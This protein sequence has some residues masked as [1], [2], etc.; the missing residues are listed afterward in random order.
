LSLIYKGYDREGLDRQY[1]LRSLWPDVPAVIDRREN[2]SA[3]VR[4]RINGRLD[5]AYGESAGERLD[6]F[7]PSNSRNGG[8]ALIYIHGGYWQLSDKNDT[9]YIAPAFL[10]AGINFITLNYTLAPA[11]T[12][13]DMVRQCRQAVAWIWHHAAEIG[14]NR[15]RLHLAGHSAGGH[16]TAMMLATDWTK[17]DRGLP[18]DPIAG[19]CALSGLYDLEPIRL[20]FV[21]DVLGLEAD[22]VIRNSPLYLDPLLNIPVILS[23]G[24]NE[25]DE[26]KR[27][28]KELFSAWSAKGLAVEQILAPDCHHYTIVEH[29]GD[30][31]GELHRA[32]I[33]MMR[34]D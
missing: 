2:E 22:A 15:D 32:M 27:H 20:C 13:D 17:F 33:E 12:L 3:R 26:F 29:F 4:E 14:I 18:P 30:P 31:N 25:T 10:D 28:Q 16:L 19:A 1:D 24:E 11:A 34:E 5:I 6:I 8:P 7:P 21:N 23:V 9:T